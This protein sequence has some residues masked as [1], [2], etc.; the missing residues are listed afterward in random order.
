ME[1]S[2]TGF[3]TRTYKR[4]IAIK[5]KKIK[6]LCEGEKK[7]KSHLKCS[8]SLLQHTNSNT[9]S[10]HPRHVSVAS[11]GPPCGLVCHSCSLPSVATHT[12]RILEI[13]TPPRPNIFLTWRGSAC[14]APSPPLPSQRLRRVQLLIWTACQGCYWRLAKRLSHT[15]CGEEDKPSGPGQADVNK[16][17]LHSLYGLLILPRAGRQREAEKVT[18]V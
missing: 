4:I 8:H 9:E 3:L 2:R 12:T 14:T 18:E 11:L 16:S 13:F 6:K 10:T 5:A 7:K 15:T 1:I 17:L